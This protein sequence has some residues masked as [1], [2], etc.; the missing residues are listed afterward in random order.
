[1]K[2]AGPL[3]A[4]GEKDLQKVFF[5]KEEFQKE[6]CGHSKKRGSYIVPECNCTRKT[7]SLL[8]VEELETKV[9]FI[10]LFDTFN[11]GGNEIITD[12]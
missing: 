9:I 10:S 6:W 7:W 2:I 8:N 11:F 12:K 4:L 5:G 3:G 1:M